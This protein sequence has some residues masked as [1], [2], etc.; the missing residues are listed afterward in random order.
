MKYNLI[1]GPSLRFSFDSKLDSLAFN[2]KFSIGK[3]SSLTARI[4]SKNNDNPP[5]FSVK[6]KVI[7]KHVLYIKRKKK[8]I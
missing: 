2:S 6:A 4:S 7:F 5:N 1:K 3:Q 8:L